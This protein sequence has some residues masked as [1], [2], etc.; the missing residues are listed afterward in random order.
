M[1]CFSAGGGFLQR[2]S[3]VKEGGD[4]L[5]AGIFLQ[6]ESSGEVGANF[7]CGNFL[8]MESRGT[9]GGDFRVRVFFTNR[10]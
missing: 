5:D 2:E 7:G 1:V 6:I 4:F 10:K 9:E 3:R 8:Q